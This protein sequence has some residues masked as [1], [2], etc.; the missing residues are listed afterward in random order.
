MSRVRSIAGMR[1]VMAGIRAHLEEIEQHVQTLASLPRCCHEAPEYK[2][3]FDHAIDRIKVS[4]DLTLGRIGLSQEGHVTEMEW[5]LENPQPYLMHHTREWPKHECA[6][7]LLPRIGALEAQVRVLAMIKPKEAKK[8][9][10][11]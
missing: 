5:Q 8:A 7:D 3:A 10:R 6:C 2:R 9:G 1:H 4:T 11:E